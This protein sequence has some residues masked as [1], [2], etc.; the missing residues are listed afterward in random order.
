M[1]KSFLKQTTK[2][3]P[4]KIPKVITKRATIKLSKII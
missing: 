3:I 2:R 1:R 4:I